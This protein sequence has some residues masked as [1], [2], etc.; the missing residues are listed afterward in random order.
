MKNDNLSMNKMKKT[1]QKVCTAKEELSEVSNK[2][3]R[4]VNKSQKGGQKL[5]MKAK[6]GKKDWKMIIE[7]RRTP[8]EIL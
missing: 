3:L 2:C 1:R 7:L 5:K 4:I 6:L 8:Q